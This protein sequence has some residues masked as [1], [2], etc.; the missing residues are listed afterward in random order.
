[1]SITYIGTST[2][3]DI[4]QLDYSS[5]YSSCHG[6]INRNKIKEVYLHKDTI[7]VK[8]QA[9]LNCP[10]LKIVRMLKGSL[11]RIFDRA[12]ANCPELKLV[13]LGVKQIGESA[14]ENSGCDDGIDFKFND[15][16]SIQR[17]AF[18]NAKIKKILLP[19]TVTCIESEAFM[20]AQFKDTEFYVPNG[21]V[22]LKER[23][24]KDSNLTDI[25]LSDNCIYPGDLFSDEYKFRIHMSKMLFDFLKP[26]TSDNII[27][28]GKGASI[29][30]LIDFYTF[31]QLNDKRLKE[32][33]QLDDNI[34][35]P[36]INE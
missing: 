20:G 15:T 13:Q 23:V 9:F 36:D 30:D 28:D 8:N 25:Y 5:D 26:T 16:T 14:F 1:M 32:E 4:N 29:N 19:V 7:S 17:K 21:V 18:K 22:G 24:F 34:E 33:I 27:V 11:W 2:G 35:E 31:K 3:L 6:P 10:D 12:F